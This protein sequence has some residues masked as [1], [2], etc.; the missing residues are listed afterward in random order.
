MTKCI[1]FAHA[2]VC[3]QTHS[4]THWKQA[5]ISVKVRMNRKPLAKLSVKE[6]QENP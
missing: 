5:Q 2:H 1:N 3:M 6:D 4:H